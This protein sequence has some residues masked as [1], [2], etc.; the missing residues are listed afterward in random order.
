MPDQ[1]GKIIARERLR[2]LALGYYIS[3]A[4]GAVFASFLIFHVI[5]FGVFSFIP[6][7]EWNAPPKQTTSTESKS[8]T[9]GETVVK[10]SAS[11]TAPPMIIFRIMACAMGFVMV[12][13]WILG[14]LTIYAGRCVQKRKHKVF[15]YVMGSLNLVW[16][17]YGTLLGIATFLVLGNEAA[18]REFAGK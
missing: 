3:G 2:L 12:C 4:I 1:E 8:E 9:S 16:L 15:I 17:P 13:G 10:P 14:G 5:M 7:K 18:G 11:S 6:E